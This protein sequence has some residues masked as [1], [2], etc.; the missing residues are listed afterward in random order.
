MEQ[1]IKNKM[2]LDRA[3]S[4]FEQKLLPA[5]EDMY[6]KGIVEFRLAMLSETHFIVHPIGVDGETVDVIWNPFGKYNTSTNI[7]G[8]Q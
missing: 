5:L 1:E 3:K 6:S 7:E 8:E 2:G 4:Q